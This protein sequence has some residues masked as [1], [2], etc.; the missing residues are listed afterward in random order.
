MAID[1]L[2]PIVPEDRLNDTFKALAHRGFEPALRMLADIAATV[3]DKD[4]NFVKDFQTT[5][6]DARLWELYLHAYLRSHGFTLDEK[7][8]VPDYIATKAAR[9]VFIEA[10]TVNPTQAKVADEADTAAGELA[11]WDLFSHRMQ[12]VYTGGWLATVAWT[13]RKKPSG[14]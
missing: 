3:N 13:R 1:L 10:V 8:P 9:T 11:G 6:F 2:T 12:N 4:G 7:N 14:R 5:G